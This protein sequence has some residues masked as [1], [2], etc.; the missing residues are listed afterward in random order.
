[1]LDSRDI[2]GLQGAPVLGRE[3][4]KLGHVGQVFLDSQSGAPNWVTV[5]TGLFGHKETFVPLANATWNGEEVHVDIDKETLKEA[6]RIDTD[7]SLSPHNE[8]AL[9]RYYGL[10]DRDTDGGTARPDEYPDREYTLGRDGQTVTPVPV[11]STDTDRVHDLDRDGSETHEGLRDRAALRDSDGIRETSRDD[12]ERDAADREDW[13]DTNAS[14]R[15]DADDAPRDL[16]DL[17]PEEANQR[18]NLRDPHDLRMS[19]QPLGDPAQPATEGTG[20]GRHS[21]MRR[22]DPAADGDRIIDPNDPPRNV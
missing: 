3:N 2:G 15:T 17:H 11:G 14:R 6:P 5:K 12:I 21:R 8:E 20:A 10:S 9:Y 4:E 18:G 1:M 19:E 22:Y 16:A 13:S 7:E